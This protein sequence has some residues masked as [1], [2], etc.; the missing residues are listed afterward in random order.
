MK[1]Y[2][3]F[4]SENFHFLVTKFS[5]YLNRH[6]FVMIWIFTSRVHVGPK[7]NSSHGAV[8]LELL[9]LSRLIQQKT[10]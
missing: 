8:H 9:P 3:K 10:N 7:D 4:L 1:K 2:Q 6:V 5:V